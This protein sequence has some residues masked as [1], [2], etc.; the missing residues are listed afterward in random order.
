[1]D[2]QNL[3]TKFLMNIG[4]MQPY[5]LPY[6]GYFQLI[7]SV[8]KFVLL[9]DVSF[10]KRG[11]INRNQILLNSNPHKITIPL[12][13]A[14]Q[15]KPINEH[16]ISYNEEWQSKIINTLEMA[17]RKAPFYDTVFPLLKDIILYNEQNLSKYIYNSIK[18]ICKF[19][20]IDTEIVPSSSVY[21]KQDLS[22]QSRIL[23][24]CTIENADR[25]INAIGGTELYQSEPFQKNNISLN[26]I[27]M[28]TDIKYNQFKK[29]IFIPHLSIADVLMFNNIERMNVLLSE[30]TII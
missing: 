6:L 29:E 11:W 20:S 30:Y 24:I 4:I 10:I 25:Y 3:K 19:L 9:D 14:S 18:T 17:Y 16:E 7:K 23:N 21:P 27:K 15:N 28:N 13:K 2:E 1:M 26:F 22:G 8:D 12:I 5:F